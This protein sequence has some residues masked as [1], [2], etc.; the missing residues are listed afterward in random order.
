MTWEQ[1]AEVLA[2]EVDRL[3]KENDRLN[4]L[5][6]P[7]VIKLP[8]GDPNAGNKPLVITIKEIDL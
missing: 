8:E 3:Q 7:A 2:K 1:T 5:I 6:F 4:A